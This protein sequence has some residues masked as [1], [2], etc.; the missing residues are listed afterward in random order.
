MLKRY[1]NF[2]IIIAILA[3][4][5]AVFAAWRD[6]P[7]AAPN[8]GAVSPDTQ[9]DYK[10][11]NLGD[12]VQTKTGGL[13]IIGNIG[14]GTTTPAVKLDTKGVIRALTT[15]D[16]LPTTGT[17]IELWYNTSNDYGFISATNR[18]AGQYKALY[19]S[20][21]G[22]YLN[23][24]GGNVGI[25]TIVPGARLAVNHKV[26]ASQDGSSGDSIYAYANSANAAISA[27]QGDTA[28]YA[29]YASGKSAFMTGNVGIGTTT[30]QTALHVVGATRT[31][32][33]LEI[34]STAA[35]STA[36]SMGTE[37]WAKYNS[38]GNQTAVA[39]IFGLRTSTANGSYD[40]ELSFLTRATGSPQV[41]AMRINRNGLVGI[42]TPI[43][44]HKMDIVGDVNVTGTYL[45]NGVAISSGVVTGSGTLGTI[46]KWTGSGGS[47][48]NSI[49]YENNNNIGIG[50][51]APGQKL[52]VS[53][54]VAL[55]NNVA[56]G[57]GADANSGLRI[58]APISTT[59][60]N[61]MIG[62]QQNLD[63]AIE[64]TPSTVVGGTI[65]NSPAMTINQSGDITIGGSGTSAG[66]WL[67]SSD[68]RLK[69]NVETL[70]GALE[71]VGRI[72]GV[73]YNL[74]SGPPGR[75]IGVIAQE[76]EQEFPELVKTDDKG[77]KAVAYDKLSAVLI[78]AIKELQSQN[79]TLRQRLDL[80]EKKW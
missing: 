34:R 12:T 11:V 80:I 19:I 50:T 71:K 65:F 68:V 31:D 74:V 29:V 43:P 78:E 64:F 2:F 56:I 8:Y 39:T 16:S 7:A 35:Y 21:A 32:G 25:G 66:G 20:S 40:G 47:L 49:I 1:L 62:A 51:T 38:S 53:G 52:H 70:S 72:R 75:Q 61:W 73:S 36:Q 59:H 58:V 15:T 23:S 76:L 67:V 26:N 3:L 5:V 37:Y 10:P 22:T 18:T 27:E 42:G 44:A 54:G 14:I 30:P 48:G 24:D 17:G 60:Y 9:A 46:S 13:N 33:G 6:A 79:Q 28:G 45:I 69:K 55:F 63:R 77:Y 57:S 4:P 41:E